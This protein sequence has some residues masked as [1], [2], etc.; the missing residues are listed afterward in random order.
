VLPHEFQRAR[1]SAT[2]RAHAR[3]ER[4]TARPHIDD[5]QGVHVAVRVDADHVVQPICKHRNHLQ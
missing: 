3:L 2:S 5:R 1:V 4:N